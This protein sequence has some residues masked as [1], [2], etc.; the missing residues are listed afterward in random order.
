[1]ELRREASARDVSIIAKLIVYII[2]RIFHLGERAGGTFSGHGGGTWDDGGV[3][4][5]ACSP[6]VPGLFTLDPFFEALPSRSAVV[7]LLLLPCI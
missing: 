2:F 3:W 7:P 6:W 1:M 4:H 5:R